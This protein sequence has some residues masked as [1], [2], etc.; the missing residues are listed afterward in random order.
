MFLLFLGHDTRLYFYG[1]FEQDERSA[2][3]SGGV[4]FQAFGAIFRPSAVGLIGLAV[5]VDPVRRPELL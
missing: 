3:E 1:K 4:V 2:T 5:R